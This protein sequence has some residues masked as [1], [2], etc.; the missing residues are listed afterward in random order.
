M[1]AQV[2]PLKQI[3]HKEVPLN[4]TLPTRTVEVPCLTIASSSESP[5]SVVNLPVDVAD[6]LASRI[7]E[8]FPFAHWRSSQTT[9]SSSAILFV[10]PADFL[11]CDSTESVRLKLHHQS[12]IKFSLMSSFFHNSFSSI[13]HSHCSSTT[14]AWATKYMC[15]GMV[16]LFG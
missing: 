1:C 8:F 6:P 13:I 5:I 4:E 15:D 14:T 11:P 9:S 7:L 10:I 16:N 2:F 12:Q 3:K